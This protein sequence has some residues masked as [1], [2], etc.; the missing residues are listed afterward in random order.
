LTI[1]LEDGPVRFDFSVKRKLLRQVEPGLRKYEYLIPTSRDQEVA[2]W[3]QAP[4]GE[5]PE[6]E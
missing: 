1:L 4:S 6:P 2:E 5:R 3:R